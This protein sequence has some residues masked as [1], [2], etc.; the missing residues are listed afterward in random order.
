VAKYWFESQVQSRHAV[1][2]ESGAYLLFAAVKMV[3]IL[4][5]APLMAFVW[6][7][8][9]EAML[10]AVGLLGVYAWRS[11]HLGD[12]RPHYS[13]A[14][15]LIEDSWPLMLSGLAVM[16]YMRIDQIM[17]GQML[18][19]EAVGIFSAAVRVSEVWYFV[20]IAIVASA[21]PSI[22]EA[23]QQSE[24]LYY[25][26]LQKLYDLMTL[27][28]L[29]VALSL[30][31]ISDWLV[32]LLYGN[33]YRGAGSVLALHAWSGLFVFLGVASSRWY[34]SEN[35][36]KLAFAR[37]LAG[38]FINI[39]A[40]VFLIPEYGVQGAAVGTL[41]SQFAAAYLFDLMHPKTRIAFWMKT[42]SF[43]PFLRY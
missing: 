36:Q 7:A 38:A 37:T 13:R 21:F 6:A 24:S 27:L 22:F 42:K 15:T 20:P 18:G 5:E 25:G 9:A 23:K 11:G 40:N 31:L 28:A 3:L 14:K 8:L 35:L 29:G 17:L 34:L 19:D 4:G 33:G 32:T 10:V 39:L 16:V 26:R 41:L 12:W 30:T 43:A 1:W 2:V